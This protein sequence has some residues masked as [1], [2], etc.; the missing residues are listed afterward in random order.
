[1]G[2][3]TAC[4]YPVPMTSQRSPTYPF[5]PRSTATLTPGQFWAIPLSDGSFGC[6]RVIELKPPQDVGARTMFLAAVLD[7]RDD[8]VPTSDAIAG[9][10]CLAQGQAHLK[11]IT[12]TGGRILGHRP[13]ELDQI[14][15]WEFRGAACHTNSNVHRGLRALRPQEPTDR[16]LPVLSTWGFGVP[17][18]IAEGQF[19]NGKR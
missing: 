11:V 16:S 12:E 10:K 14:E 9:A 8:Q 2:G 5:V 3:L 17:V 15:P 19:I 6:G 18:I 1:M 7:W 13:L 4:T